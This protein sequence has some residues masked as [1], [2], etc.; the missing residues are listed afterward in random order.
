LSRQTTRRLRVQVQVSSQ[1]THHPLLG[2][3]LMNRTTQRLTVREPA[4]TQTDSLMALEMA[5]QR[6]L[7]RQVR[8]QESIQTVHQMLEQESIQTVHQMLEQESIQTVH[9]M[10]ELELHRIMTWMEQEQRA[11]T[12]TDQSTEQELSWLQLEV[13]E[14]WQSA[15]P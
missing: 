15:P 13:E 5:H 12:Q 10:R 2:Q 4:L 14:P 6:D 9:Q 1:T 3:E 11:S 7:H 8:E